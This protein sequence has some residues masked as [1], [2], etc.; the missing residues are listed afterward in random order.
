M[1]NVTGFGTV[2]SI[3]ASVTFPAGIT[4]TNFADDSDPLDFASVKIGDAAMGVNGDLITWAKAVSKP[5][6][7]NVIPGSQDDVNLSILANA[8]NASVGK[9]SANDV[10]TA[11]VVYP[12]AS[13]VTHTNGVI[14][15]AMLG[16]S[17]ASAG[18]LKTKTY[19]FAFE[20][21]TGN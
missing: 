2:I 7:L 18:R 12:D 8:N 11:T 16:K 3:V 1:Q 4:I 13:T 14:T 9:A 17:I 10:I 15:D 5:M 19:A 20:S 6:V 21:N